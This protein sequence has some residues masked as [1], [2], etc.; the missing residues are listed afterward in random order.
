MWLHVVKMKMTKQNKPELKRQ[1]K[2]KWKSGQLFIIL[3][4]AVL[5]LALSI[6]D[7]SKKPVQIEAEE[8]TSLLLDEH[9][10]SFVGGG[11]INQNKLKQIQSMDYEK[12]KSYLNIK[13]DFCIYVEDENGQIILSKVAPTLNKDSKACRSK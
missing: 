6:Y 7:Y 10:L 3:I 12:L 11:V 4:V 8:I 1:K 9:E 2:E 5:A 13:N